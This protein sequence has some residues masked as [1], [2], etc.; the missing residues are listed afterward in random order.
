[1]PYCPGCGQEMS[2]KASFCTSCGSSIEQKDK[3]VT[4]QKKKS[5]IIF[6]T[7]IATL[8]VVSAGLAFGLAGNIS[9]KELFF[10]AIAQDWQEFFEPFKAIFG[11]DGELAKLTASESHS[12]RI[13]IAASVDE[14]IPMLKDATLLLSGDIDPKQ[15]MGSYS[16]ALL[17]KGVELIKLELFQ[18]DDLT[19]LRIPLWREDYFFLDN[20]NLGEFLQKFDADYVGLESIPNLCRLVLNKNK[21]QN[22]LWTPY[23]DKIKASLED[24]QFEL[25]NNVSFQGRKCKKITLVLSGTEVKDIILD[26]LNQVAQDDN[27]LSSLSSLP[28]DVFDQDVDSPMA[29]QIILAAVQQ[30]IKQSISFPNG[31]RCEVIV[32]GDKILSNNTILAVGVGGDSVHVEYEA[33][34]HE[35]NGTEVIKRVLSFKEHQSE[36]VLTWESRIASERVETEISIQGA[37]ALISAKLD[38]AITGGTRKTD[39]NF[40]LDNSRD[41]YGASGVLTYNID[42]NLKRGFSNRDWL[43]DLKLLSQCRENGKKETK[44]GVEIKSALEFHD[45]LVFPEIKPATAINLLDLNVTEL[46]KIFDEL[47]LSIESIFLP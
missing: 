5:R 28:L 47:V 9:P 35:D 3:A 25:E 8:L 12:N 14:S 36:F 32:D 34:T 21:P 42:Q 31:F 39:F 1:M 11:D 27:I 16:T 38:T 46:E 24:K 2:A 10:K 41:R 19:A 6:I 44:F 15:A 22:N 26:L 30:Q 45:N 17:M 29:F 43:L 7:V 33:N 18:S 37:Q 40:I 20:D 13:S 23:G 4:S